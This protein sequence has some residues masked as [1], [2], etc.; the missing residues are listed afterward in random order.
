MTLQQ[1]RYIV[2]ID[3]YR[4]FGKAAEACGLT[5]STLS[6]MV[7]KLEEELDVRL[8]DR[9]AHPVSPT[10]I[11]R[12]VIDQAKVV[13]Y[14]VEQVAQLTRSEK[15]SLSGPLRIALI[16]TVSP[17]LVPGLFK[18]LGEQHPT[19][20]LQT[21]EMLTGTIKDR[22]RKAEVDM[23]IL[24]G[25]VREPGLLEI[26]LYHERFLAY[27]S[28]D[29]PAYAQESL[30]RETLAGQPL[31][32]IRDGLRLLDTKDLQEGDFSYERY[33]EGGRVGILIQVVNDNG[34]ITIIPETHQGFILYSQQH[35]IR[36]IVDPVPS[37]TISLVI[38]NDY[39]HEAKLN[40]VV[41]AVKRIV[42]GALL[43]NVL[44]KGRLVL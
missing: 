10:E 17:V 12:K 15:E 21:E 19:L 3:D 16:S 18:Y 31:W 5:Q 11:G 30:R 32:I 42:P 1:L 41:D 44:R 20:S 13:L 24:A 40:A 38:R 27:V 33:F 29:N 23:G 39:I 26:P 6:L 34:G 2:A 25:P 28:P 35:C 7:K 36:P 14:H 22:L 43:D 4:H 8:F 9:D 37:R